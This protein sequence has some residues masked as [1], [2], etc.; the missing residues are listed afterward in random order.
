MEEI[1]KTHDLYQNYEFS[2]F[3]RFRKLDTKKLLKESVSIDKHRGRT[4]GYVCTMLLNNQTNKRH[5]VKL[6]RIVGELFVYNP[7]PINKTCINHKDGNK[8]N[9][10]YTNL[11]WVSVSE[12]NK[13]AHATDLGYSK[14][15][16][17]MIPLIREEYVNE[18]TPINQLA[19]RYNVTR[20]TIIGILTYNIRPYINPEKKDYY[21]KIFNER[22]VKPDKIELSKETIDSI[23]RNYVEGWSV[24]KII[25]YHSITITDFNILVSENKLP[26]LLIQP[27][28]ILKPYGK[29]QISNFGRV[30]YDDKVINKKTIDGKN[31]ITIV[32]ILFLP[33]TNNYKYIRLINDKLPLTV[34]NL[35]W[36]TNQTIVDDITKLEIINQY[37]T[38]DV[39]RRKLKKQYKISEVYLNEILINCKKTKKIQPRLCQTCGETNPDKF[40]ESRKTSCKKC[41]SEKYR[42]PYIKKG[43]RPY[44]CKICDETNPDNFSGGSKGK[45][46]KCKNIK[47]GSRPH[48]CKICSETNPD[49]FYKGSKGCCKKCELIKYKNNRTF[50]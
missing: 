6:H 34:F 19:L 46:N 8:I 49:K 45:C 20:Q 11:E 7:D 24:K 2:S 12:N 16:T 9:N 50:L 43:P 4:T 37:N 33:N 28:E 18:N 32:G 30:I 10:H 27:N 23:L 26:K 3:G 5:R 1:W 17:K 36:Y 29:Y 47:K 35:E 44:L 40:K 41:H 25:N 31:I 48:L 13:H 38:T 15:G 22:N 42:K 39:T 14:I 21:V